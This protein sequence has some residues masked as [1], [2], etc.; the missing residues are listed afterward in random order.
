MTNFKNY[1]K[2]KKVTVMRIGLLGR[3][4]G[5][6]AYLA[7]AG[8]QVLVVDSASAEVMQ[9]AINALSQ[10][11]N[12]TFSFGQYNFADFKDADLVLV[13]AGAPVDEPVLVECREAGVRLVQSAALF[14]E[15]SKI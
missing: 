3:G 4:I 11:P 7:E 2:D 13:G 6:T 5:D 14:A 8:A 12:V 1:F 9:P 10:Y 15:I